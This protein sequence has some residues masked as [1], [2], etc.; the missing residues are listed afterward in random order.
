MGLFETTAATGLYRLKKGSAIVHELLAMQAGI[1]LLND[2]ID[3]LERAP[4]ADQMDRLQLEQACLRYGLD[5]SDKCRDAQLRRAVKALYAPLSCSLRSIESFFEK[6]GC[7]IQLE[8]RPE[9]CVAV[10]GAIGGLFEDCGALCCLLAKLLPQDCKI[11]EELGV[12]TW[13]MIDAWDVT[14]TDFDAQDFTWT[15]FETNGHLLDDIWKG[16]DVNG[17][18]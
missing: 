10:K 8:E 3:R 15:W 13:N 7:N 2:R 16:R 17:K 5:V 4:F 1:D 12:L 9:R 11:L 6:M 18:Q 14:V